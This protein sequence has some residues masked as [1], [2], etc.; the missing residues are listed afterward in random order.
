M[1]SSRSRLGCSASTALVTLL[2]AI[3]V[4]AKDRKITVT[5]TC[6]YTIW[7]G[8]LTSVGPKPSQATGWEM[9]P[10]STMSFN[11]QESWGGRIWPRTGC[12]F[13][14]SSKPDYAQ[15]E[16][17]GC[18]GGLL[19]TGVPPC[20]LAEFNIQETIDHYD[21]S[22]VDGYNV[23]MAIT[24]S[25]DC[26]MANCPYDLLGSC[27]SDQQLKNGKGAVVGCKTDC[28]V[29]PENE[30]YCCSGG[31]ATPDKCP[32]SGIPHY[33][34]WKDSCP[35][36]YVYAYDESSGT[37]L[38][39]CTKRVDWIITFCPD[40][41]LYQTST[42]VLQTK[43]VTQG[44]GQKTQSIQKVT[45]TLGAGGGG[46]NNASQTSKPSSAGAS[47]PA[48]TGEAASSGPAAASSGNAPAQTGA[49]GASSTGAGA[50]G[51]SATSD[52]GAVSPTDTGASGATP[53]D[54]T[55]GTTG[56]TGGS[57]GSTGSSSGDTS[58]SDSSSSS[59]TIFGLSPTVV[60]SAAAVSV[61]LIIGGIA[62]AVYSS[63]N[64]SKR[65]GHAAVKSDDSSYSDSSSD[66]EKGGSSRHKKKKKDDSSSSDSSDD[67]DRDRSLA[68]FS[69]LEQAEKRAASESIYAQAARHPA[70][71]AG[72]LGGESGRAGSETL[73]ELPRGPDSSGSEAESLR[74]PSRRVLRQA[75]Q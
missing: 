3:G 33:K 1:R 20:T 52:G 58:S 36:S 10:G 27:S 56:G 65:H 61:L 41:S 11:V 19:C 44:S 57:S 70:G 26:P 35:Y 23:P 68:K 30:E 46:G 5:N 28:A 75:Y 18:K 25:A 31:H 38:F 49:A 59:D 2:L 29:H 8:L 63:R 51:A 50:S 60:Y 14:D 39:T 12:D 54:T 43:T 71:L 37:A 47:Q 64:K 67:D 66:D 55:G 24:N 9:P 7:A 4:D 34:W 17:G 74:A 69:A 72:L 45:T 48:A 16:S 53:T 73:F 42:V 62:F 32:A 21:S 15:C 13:S 6:T 22:L 40:S